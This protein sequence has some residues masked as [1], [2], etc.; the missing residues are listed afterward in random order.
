MQQ[1]RCLGVSVKSSSCC[2][3]ALKPTGSFI[4]L[5]YVASL[6]RYASSKTSTGV[7]GQVFSLGFGLSCGFSPLISQKWGAGALS[8]PWRW[9]R[10]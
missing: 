4:S 2:G 1:P 9:S 8:A 3:S 6:H 7:F 5:A 10:C